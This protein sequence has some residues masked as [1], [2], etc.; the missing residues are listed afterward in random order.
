L[1]P[2]PPPQSAIR[3]VDQPLHDD[4][5]WLA[6]ALGRVIQ[7]VE[8]E[9]AFETVESLRVASRNRRRGE[10]GAPTLES[11]LAEVEALPL[12]L[13]A[14]T[15]R[16]FTLFFLLINTAEQVH[17]VRRARAYRDVDVDDA[18]PQPASA[19][20]TMQ[21][22]RREG[23]TAAEVE[24]A[25][26]GLHVRP[27]LTAHPTESTR[28]TLLA[29]QA[30]VAGALLAR[31]QTPASERRAVEEAL[32]AEV[33]LLWSTAEIRQDR[34]T[35]KDEVSTV[36]WYLETRLLDAGATAR[37]RLVRAYEEEFGDASEKLRAIV[38]LQLG[39]WVGGDRDGNPFVT[40][41]IT[42]ATARRASYAILG[43]YHEVLIGLIERL[44]M[45]ATLMKH[46]DALDESL[47]AS[48]AR[49][50]VLMPAVWEANRLRNADE[51]VR[52]KLTFMAARMDATRTRTAARDAGR[53]VDAPAA[54]AFAEDFLGELQLIRI[55]M[56]A[57]GAIHACRVS[58]DP[59]VAAVRAYGFFGYL[60][61][62]RD[63]AD[64]HAAAL[65]DIGS[66][67]GLAPFD[68][69]ALRAELAGRRPLVSDRTQLAEGTRRVLN[70]FGAIRTIQ[71][72][73]GERAASTYIVSM[74]T[75]AEDLLRV[76]LLGRESGLVDLA[77][78]PPCSSIDVVPLF[79]TLDDLERAPAVM[80]VLLDD[81]IYRRQLKAR[82]YRQE[83]MIGYSDSGK[84][85]GILASSWALY[86][87][88]AALATLFAGSGVLLTLFHGRGG[89]VG[90]GGGSPVARALAALPPG[91][92]DGRI[93]ITEQGE[94]ISQQFGL[95]PVA[96]RTLEVTLAG[97]L[98]HDF[99]PWPSH[100][101]EPR[102]AR[103]RE[104]MSRL[105]ATGLAVYRDLVHEHDALFT[106]F[107]TVTPIAELA[108]ARFGSRPAYR[109]GAASGI[110]G[111]RA[112][113]WGFGWTQIRLMLTGWLGAGTALSTMLDE[114]EGEAI[115]RDMVQR[116]PFFD[117]LI[118]KIEM[119]C[120]KTD[121]EIARAYVTTLGGDVDLLGRLEE[122]F[123]RTVAAL[124]RIRGTSELLVDT[125]VL[126]A[127]IG[128]RNP[129]VDPLSLLQIALLK[130]KRAMPEGD[131]ARAPLDAVLSTTLS[132][133]AQG[134]RNT[135]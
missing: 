90:R 13:S 103:Y 55:A 119:V 113:P 50:R 75:C 44:S 97:A 95:L 59:F 102:M 87:G 5:R 35:V 2:S 42:L 26:F 6:A 36:L 76:L 130:K 61:D 86:E 4:V 32:D 118:G 47:A 58:L 64:T 84:D 133:I 125:P 94:I 15:A 19:R 45:S 17:R 24:R 135:G 12:E 48:L 123:H 111:I 7:R 83:V 132:G 78:E 82:G 98:M 28:R 30:R 63:H 122:E 85:A 129:Y 72:E 27:V 33:E 60:M 101:G 106:L 80:R 43:R 91:T 69:E 70:T 38:P 31:E 8:G 115:L 93:K 49:D 89:S 25:M 11:L 52:L 54:Y 112:I 110:G 37:D 73:L 79:E 53:A 18:P 120:A 22:L 108:D 20:W 96:E 51:P 99:N 21:T 128:L 29:L 68:G 117:D 1:E 3:A 67:V 10:A 104:V 16:A 109:P 126:Q 92:V 88:Q 46:S 77:A 121:L 62:V 107:R 40:P 81:P 65:D 57:S 134:L 131:P 34:P 124:L 41:A 105:A 116:W 66:R 9:T 100:V 14:I 74:T 39:N 71:G 23:R 114:P 56:L 127:A